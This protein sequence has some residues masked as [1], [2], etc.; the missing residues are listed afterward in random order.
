MLELS[1]NT[2]N[3]ISIIDDATE[4]ILTIFSHRYSVPRMLVP[5]SDEWFKRILPNYAD[6]QFKKFMRVSREDFRKI[7]AL[8]ENNDIFKGPNSKKQLEID[9]QLALTL[10]KFGNDGTGSGIVNTA[11]L[12]GVGGG[13]SVMK[14]V[15][16]VI[17]V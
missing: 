16:R 17:K 7:L 12:F 15:V 8:I 1:V 14:I 2:L 6:D 9:Q 3:H 5:K 4:D 13:G 11:A 10:Y